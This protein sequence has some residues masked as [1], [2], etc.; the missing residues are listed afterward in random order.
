MNRKLGY[1]LATNKKIRK[2]K[3]IFEGSLDYTFSDVMD[4]DA[5]MFD[6]SSKASKMSARFGGNPI[7]PFFHLT[8]KM[9]LQTHGIPTLVQDPSGKTAGTITWRLEVPGM[10]MN[11][12]CDPNAIDYP[13]CHD[14][15]MSYALRNVKKGEEL[16]CDYCLQFYD[17][18]PFFDKCCCGA[19]SCRGSMMGFKGLSQSEKDRIFPSASE[20][21][22]TMYMADIGKGLPNKKDQIVHGSRKCTHGAPR[23]V[24]G[25]P[26]F[27]AADV[28]VKQNENYG[29]PGNVKD[30]ALYS[31]K[32]YSVGDRV[33]EFWCQAWPIHLPEQFDMVFS[34]PIT[35]GDPPEGTGETRILQPTLGIPYF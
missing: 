24:C 5:V 14:K 2:G 4:G 11:H 27:A 26:S 25:G 32:N 18:G 33:Y 29:N 6:R 1:G 19:S 34:S 21:V 3:M 13:Q 15:G 20:A 16:T 12:S 10:L 17:E 31:L 30:C 35:E 8:C 23:L 9:L 22:Q 28:I 7:P